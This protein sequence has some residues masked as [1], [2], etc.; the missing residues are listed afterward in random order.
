EARA[1]ACI[2]DVFY[3]V[4]GLNSI[5]MGGNTSTSYWSSSGAVTAGPYGS[6]ASNGSITLSGSTYVNG[7]ARAPTVNGASGRVAGSTQP[8]ATPMSF[9]NGDAGTY[10]TVNDNAVVPQIT[11][12]KDFKVGAGVT[13]TVPAG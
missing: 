6:I 8:L 1:V 7:D 5:S 10:A 11:G 13:A 3:G 2:P 9:P 4:V 12:A